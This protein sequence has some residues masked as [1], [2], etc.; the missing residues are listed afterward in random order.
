M[1]NSY[2][3]VLKK[4][5]LD[6]QTFLNPKDP[7][8]APDPKTKAFI[9]SKLAIIQTKVMPVAEK[10][11]L[12]MQ[13]VVDAQSVTCYHDLSYC[14]GIKRKD[15]EGN[16][17]KDGRPGKDCPWRD[18]ARAGLHIGDELYVKKEVVVWQLLAAT[19]RSE[20]WIEENAANL[21]QPA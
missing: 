8:K 20:Q 10:S 16:I 13:D 14:C 2:V 6:M 19:E 18:A 9:E 3:E 12:T 4:L 15:A 17:I 21:P 7:K 5:V 11:T 1:S